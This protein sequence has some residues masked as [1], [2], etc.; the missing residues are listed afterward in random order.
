MSLAVLGSLF[1]FSDS[2][3]NTA[4][5]AAWGDWADDGNLAVTGLGAVVG[6]TAGPTVR[7]TLPGINK[8]ANMQFNMAALG[9]FLFRKAGGVPSTQ[10]M[11]YSWACTLLLSVWAGKQESSRIG[12]IRALAGGR[13]AKLGDDLANYTGITLAPQ[14]EWPGQQAPGQ[15]TPSHLPAGRSWSEKATKGAHIP[16]VLRV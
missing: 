5:G 13:L 10:A 14:P 6:L 16:E 4:T 11:I 2:V 3:A 7:A 1:G 12:D 9:Y 8:L 15:I